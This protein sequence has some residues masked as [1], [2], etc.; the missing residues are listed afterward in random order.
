LLAAQLQVFKLQLLP[1]FVWRQFF[2]CVIRASYQRSFAVFISTLFQ[3]RAVPSWE[4]LDLASESMGLLFM[5][6]SLIAKPFS[7][8]FEMCNSSSQAKRL[9]L[10]NPSSKRKR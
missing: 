6:V 7:V 5:A 8:Y 10:H 3:A 9:L 2:F 1:F 4:R